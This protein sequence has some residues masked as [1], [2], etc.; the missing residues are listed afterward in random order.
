MSSLLCGHCALGTIEVDILRR[1]NGKGPADPRLSPAS[2][3]ALPR[4]VTALKRFTCA[5]STDGEPPTQPP[6]ERVVRYFAYPDW[7]F[8][9]LREEFP[10]GA[11]KRG[12]DI[13]PDE[14]T[15]LRIDIDTRL[16]VAVNEPRR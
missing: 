2:A 13:G 8:D 10:T 16:M 1:L 6:D 5:R 12:A 7:K 9:R 3:P 4:V 14:W 15:N 11:T